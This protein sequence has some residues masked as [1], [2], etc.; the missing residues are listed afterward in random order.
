MWLPNCSLSIQFLNVFFHYYFFQFVDFNCFLFEDQGLFHV[1][2][3]NNSITSSMNISHVFSLIIF[4][5]LEDWA[6]FNFHMKMQLQDGR[7]KPNTCMINQNTKTPKPSTLQPKMKTF[8]KKITKYS[9]FSSMFLQAYANK[10]F[11]ANVGLL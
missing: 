3:K 9:K 6:I 7:K 11:F 8:T 5:F 10:R 2:A 4:S 1:L